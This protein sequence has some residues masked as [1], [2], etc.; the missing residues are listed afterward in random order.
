MPR[1]CVTR[2]RENNLDKPLLDDIIINSLCHYCKILIHGHFELKSSNRYRQ[3]RRYQ[4]L[5]LATQ[6]FRTVPASSGQEILPSSPRSSGCDWSLG[7]VLPMRKV[8]GLSRMSKSCGIHR[9]LRSRLSTLS[10]RSDVSTPVLDRLGEAISKFPEISSLG[11]T[12]AVSL[13]ARRRWL[14]LRDVVAITCSQVIHLF[15]MV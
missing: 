8:L 11:G 10:A 5:I 12:M 2:A 15:S 1:C 7:R 3:G 14:S 4:P 13:A 9:M 6:V